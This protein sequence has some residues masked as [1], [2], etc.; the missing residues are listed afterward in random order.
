[1]PALLKRIPSFPAAK[2]QP[3]PSSPLVAAVIASV[4]G[5]AEGL[6]GELSHREFRELVRA[7]GRSCDEVLLELR[8]AA[9]QRGVTT[10]S[11]FDAKRITGRRAS[12][13]AA[14][15]LDQLE[16]EN[17]RLRRLVA[18]QRLDIDALR[19]RA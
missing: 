9:L 17:A 14:V 3:E 19:G 7:R 11:A 2:T 16:S 13:V 1:M 10:P 6:R 18:D 4:G 12:A 15:R 5:G 8:R